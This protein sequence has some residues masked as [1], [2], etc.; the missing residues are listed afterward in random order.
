MITRTNKYI[1]TESIN[2]S[3]TYYKSANNFCD[4][5]K[6]SNNGFYKSFKGAIKDNPII[7]DDGSKFYCS[8]DFIEDTTISKDPIHENIQENFSVYE[9]SY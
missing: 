9:D 4:K 3:L 5:Y 1:I 2:G 8:N 7:L 6:I